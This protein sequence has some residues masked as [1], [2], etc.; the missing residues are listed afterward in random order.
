M[1]LYFFLKINA[2]RRI[3]ER[4]VAAVEIDQEVVPPP[5][6]IVEI[7]RKSV[8]STNRAETRASVTPRGLGLTH[9]EVG[10]LFEEIGHTGTA[11][12][13][14]LLNKKHSSNRQPA[15]EVQEKNPQGG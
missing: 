6:D 5:S 13:V 15:E 11:E 7:D 9:L 1:Y 10:H 14:F 8:L 4:I 12:L 2:I 3:G